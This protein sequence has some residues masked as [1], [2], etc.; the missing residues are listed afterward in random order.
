MS[1]KAL[2]YDWH[3]WNLALF[4]AINQRGSDFTDSFAAI[5]NAVGDYAAMPV[6]AGI[7]LLT[8]KMASDRHQHDTAVQLQWTARRL[9]TGFVLAWCIVATLKLGF[10]YPRPLTV[11]GAEVRVIGLPSDHYSFPSGHAS[12]AGLVSVVLWSLFRPAYRGILPIFAVWVGWSRIASGAHFPTDVVTGALIG[13]VSAWLATR[14]V[15]RLP[16]DGN[17]LASQ[18]HFHRLLVQAKLAFA[19]GNLDRSL[20]L[21]QQAHIAGHLL[22]GPHFVAH[23]WM[24]RVAIA[25]SD[26]AEIREQG[27]RIA[28]VP[29]V[30]LLGRLPACSP[31]SASPNTVKPAPES[32]GIRPI[33]KEHHEQ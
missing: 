16:K 14:L 19:A 11:L 33:L 1:L 3:G 5:G 28:V 13:M 9:M 32:T 22:L 18:I 10:D 8:A 29:V 25:R 2:L 23:L 4:K 26:W 15:L 20:A 7:L 31:E 27:I 21:L 17:F 12:Y 6:L 24:L 30:H